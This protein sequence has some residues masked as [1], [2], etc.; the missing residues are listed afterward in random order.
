MH[1]TGVNH[2]SEENLERYYLG[3]VANSVDSDTIEEHLLW[4][5]EC[6]DRHIATESYINTLRIA[7]RRVMNH[8]SA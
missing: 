4:C 6:Q 5:E 7:L 1:C 2:I 8:A 3:T